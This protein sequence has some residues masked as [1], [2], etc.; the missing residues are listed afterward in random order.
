MSGSG[1]TKQPKSITTIGFS[2]ESS[3]PAVG[4]VLGVRFGPK[5]TRHHVQNLLEKVALS[6]N[7]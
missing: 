6:L 7:L 4:S 1:R 3:L 5:A 2:L